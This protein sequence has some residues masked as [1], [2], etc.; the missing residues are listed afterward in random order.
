MDNK[1]YEGFEREEGANIA[2]AQI[3]LG[4]AHGPISIEMASALAEDHEAQLGLGLRQGG[5]VGS[6]DSSIVKEVR[7]PA[8]S[9]ISRAWLIGIKETGSFDPSQPWSMEIKTL[10]DA[11]DRNV[12]S[13]PYSPP[14][15]IVSEPIPHQIAVDH[16]KQE[17]VVPLW[18]TVWIEQKYALGIMFISFFMLSVILIL[19][20]SIMRSPKILKAIPVL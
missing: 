6:I 7:S 1:E 15:E 13:I 18:V 19:Q 3:W 14:Q 11:K 10:G 9:D 4:V 8:V 17:T 20:G 5:W 16:R 2:S 12:L